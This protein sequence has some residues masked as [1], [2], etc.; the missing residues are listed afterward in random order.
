MLARTLSKALLIVLNPRVALLS[1][2]LALS[3][4]GGAFQALAQEDPIAVVRADA[5]QLVADERFGAA[6]RLLRA[7]DLR[8]LPEERVLELKAWIASI[9]A[10]KDEAVRRVFEDA[11]ELSAQGKHDEALETLD[12]IETFGDP[13]DLERAETERT[14]IRVLLAAA[15]AAEAEAT[16]REDEQAAREAQAAARQAQK[17]AAADVVRVNKMVKSWLKK[18]K[19]LICSSCRGVGRRRCTA[20]DGRGRIPQYDMKGRMSWIDCRS[21]KEGSRRCHACKETGTN[22]AR[23]DDV[24]R[25]LPR[26]RPR[27]PPSA[28]TSMASSR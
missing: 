2:V 9:E 13:A 11:R 24:I 8:T 21:C 10:R 1:V 5:Q 7:I 14:R 17:E 23:L 4:V 19:Q 6:L 18:R 12:E 3:G 15:E 27:L 16:R 20:C 25:L 28:S 22:R 26:P